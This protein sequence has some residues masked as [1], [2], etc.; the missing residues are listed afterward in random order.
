MKLLAVETAT[1]A[2]SAALLVG[3]EIRTRYVVAAKRHTQLILPMC[4]ELFKEADLTA[5]QLDAVCFGRGPGSFTGVRIATGIIQ[6]IAFAYDLPVIPVSTLATIAQEVIVKQKHVNILCAI[7]A[8]MREIYWGMY[9]KNEQ[10]LATLVNEECVIKPEQVP[11]PVTPMWYGAGGAWQKYQHELSER[12]ATR[13]AGFNG[14]ILPKAEFVIPLAK[15]AFLKAE[16][17]SPE[18]ALP[19]YLRDNI[20]RKSST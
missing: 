2:C 6:G 5:S 17:V 13:L 19:V 18:Q 10:G 1:E 3:E 8:R 7:D 15:V 9:K 4:D 16:V 12:L 14:N 20:A 11:L